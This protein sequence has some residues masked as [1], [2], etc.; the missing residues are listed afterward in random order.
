MKGTFFLGSDSPSKFEVREMGDLGASLGPHE[1]LVKNMAAGICGTDIHIYLGEKGSAEV[2]PPVVLGHEYSGIVEKVGT[3]VTVVKVGDHVTIDPNIYCGRC[4]PC[5]MGHKQNCENLFALG[6]NVNGGFAEYCAVPQSQVYKISDGTSFEKAAMSEPVA[7][8]LHGI[9]MCNIKCGDTVAII[10]GGMI[11]LIMVQLAKLSGAAKIALIEPVAEKR[12]LGKKLGADVCIDP[13]SQE[14]ESECK[15]LGRIACVI[16]C[17]GSISTMQQAIRIAG[18]RGTVMLF[19]LTAP[20]DEMVVKPHE[21][22]EKELKITASFINPYTQGRAVALIDSG[23]ID[24]SSP[25]Y[26]ILKLNELPALLADA[27]ALKCGKY[28]IDPR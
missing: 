7:C 28:I 6:V 5:R 19:G 16:E 27:Q 15:K 24:V 17:V 26:K 14:V 20:D 23:K 9:D 11:G 10:G 8:C 13:M 4:I 12:D 21:V 25:V 22:F 3:E 1:V 18:Y 2:T